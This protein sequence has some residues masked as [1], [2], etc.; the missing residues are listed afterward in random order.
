MYEFIECVGGGGGGGGG[1][2]YRP[3]MKFT[4]TQ[5]TNGSYMPSPPLGSISPYYY[6]IITQFGQ[7]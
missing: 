5:D 1:G 4:G 6:V 7:Q 2:M 3:N